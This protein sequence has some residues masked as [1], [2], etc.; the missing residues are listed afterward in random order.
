M[1]AGAK[2]ASLVLGPF[3]NIYIANSSEGCAK[4]TRGDYYKQLLTKQK[5][6][7]LTEF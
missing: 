5:N 6:F 1:V 3:E 7:L 4:G 2:L